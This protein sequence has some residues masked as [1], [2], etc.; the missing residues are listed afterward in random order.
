MGTKRI[1][2][3]RA[4]GILEQFLLQNCQSVQHWLLPSTICFSVPFLFIRLNKKITFYDYGYNINSVLNRIEN[5]DTGI[6][7]TDYYSKPWLPDN[8]KKLK[9][10]TPALIHD[11]CLSAPLTHINDVDLVADLLLFSTG[12]GKVVDLGSGALGFYRSVY[13]ITLHP[14]AN[15]ENVRKEYEALDA[16]WKDILKDKDIFRKER[17]QAGVNWVD[18]SDYDEPAYLSDISNTQKDQTGHQSMLNNIYEQLINPS[19]LNNEIGNKWRFNILVDQP[20]ILLAHLFGQGLFASN[21]YA[22][23]AGHLN[24]KKKENRSSSYIEKHII[25]LFN[26]QHYTQEQAEQTATTINTLFHRN[27]IK[28]APDLL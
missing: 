18:T 4:L 10:L 1:V 24:H 22:S 23:A 19:F 27:L 3:F 21:H 13:D 14:V 8:V 2:G 11:C 7:L 6:L 12:N 20:Q 17:V 5:A 16:Y 15:A 9:E 25:N 28:P 26:N